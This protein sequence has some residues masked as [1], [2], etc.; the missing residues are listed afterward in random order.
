MSTGKS[1]EAGICQSGA[2]YFDQLIVGLII[3]VG[4][5]EIALLED[6]KLGEGEG[7]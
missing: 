5:G 2:C 7:G 1:E 4:G 6:V 3:N